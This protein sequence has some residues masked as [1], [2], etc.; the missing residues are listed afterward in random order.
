MSWCGTPTAAYDLKA[1]D[2]YRVPNT[3]GMTLATD[4]AGAV[5]VHLDGT[6]LGRAGPPQ[7]GL[8]ELSLD[9]QTLADSLKR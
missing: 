8:P 3:P 7:A 1:G 9:P 2:S 4:N 5:E 6:A